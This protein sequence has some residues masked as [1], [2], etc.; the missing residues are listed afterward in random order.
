MNVFA[1]TEIFQLVHGGNL[2]TGGTGGAAV[3][4][5]KA[6][7]AAVTAVTEA[8][9]SDKVYG[10]D[11]TVKYDSNSMESNVGEQRV[12]VA[13]QRSSLPIAEEEG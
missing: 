8:T 2:Q 6:K 3:K 4:P 12:V 1:K 9:V 11:T 10:T 5:P 13:K 7:L